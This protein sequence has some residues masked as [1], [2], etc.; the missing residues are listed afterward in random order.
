MLVRL[1]LLLLLLLLL[2]LLSLLVL[3]LLEISIC[4]LLLFLLVPCE[5]LVPETLFALLFTKKPTHVWAAWCR[6][7]VLPPR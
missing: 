7:Y 2:V 3:M 6:G 4:L 5:P 1:L